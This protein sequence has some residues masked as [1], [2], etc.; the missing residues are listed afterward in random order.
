MRCFFKPKF[1]VPAMTLAVC[2]AA[3]T[4][5]LNYHLGRTPT[6]EELQVCCTPITV[7]GKGLPPGSGTAKQ[8]ASIYAQKCA[9]CHGPTGAEGPQNLLS[10]AKPIGGG[11]SSPTPRGPYYGARGF[12]PVMYATTIWDYTNRGMP[13]GPT[14][15]DWKGG[16][17]LTA[18]EVYAVTAFI[19]NRNGI[20]GENDVM[21]AESLP[22]VQMPNQPKYVPTRPEWKLPPPGPQQ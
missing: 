7:D 20:I 2:I 3:Q 6:P 4:Q 18:D 15:T 14:R 16:R 19:L 13:P 10:Y 9:Q 8:G 17:L 22:K 5:G 21:D 11:E 1:F 12:G